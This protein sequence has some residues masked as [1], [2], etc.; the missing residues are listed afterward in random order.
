MG[1]IMQAKSNEQYWRDRYGMPPRV[2][3]RAVPR[4][5]AVPRRRR[6]LV[7]LLKRRPALLSPKVGPT[8]TRFASG[9]FLIVV[10]LAAFALG[11]TSGEGIYF[12]GTDTKPQ[13]TSVRSDEPRVA[14]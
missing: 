8:T 5:I 3:V 10:M 13:P 1:A 7:S 9:A 14:K 2:E 6:K 4:R 12:Q 11:M